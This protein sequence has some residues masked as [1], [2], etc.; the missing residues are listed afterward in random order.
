[1]LKF[2]AAAAMSGH[3]LHVA[4]CGESGDSPVPGGL[5]SLP[6]V[7]SFPSGVRR[8]RL[9]GLV[10]EI[11]VCKEAEEPGSR[12][13][14]EDEGEAVLCG[15]LVHVI[16]DDMQL[17]RKTSWKCQ[18][19][20]TEAEGRSNCRSETLSRWVR[21]DYLIIYRKVAVGDGA[22]RYAPPKRPRSA[23]ILPAPPQEIRKVCDTA[24]DLQILFAFAPGTYQASNPSRIFA[25][26]TPHLKWDCQIF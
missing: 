5:I 2:E 3:A 26:I 13:E 20:S 8:A 1:M 22:G 16:G 23:E 9:R 12:S 6:L 14:T 19:S 10:L 18:S 17:L 7:I 4:S 11:F 24:V 21:L 25:R 15:R